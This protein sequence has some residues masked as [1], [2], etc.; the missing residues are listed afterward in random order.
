MK[1]FR[2]LVE[3]LIVYQERHGVKFRWGGQFIA[4]TE[5]Q[6]PLS[7]YLRASEA[8]L[9]NVGIG[10]EHASERIRKLMRKGFD[11]DALDDTINNLSKSKIYTMMNFMS[12]HPLETEDDHNENLKFMKNYQWASDNG[13]I[14]SLNLQHYIAFLPGTD[15]FD[16]KDELVEYDVGP[17]WKNDNL[18][19]P[20]IHRRRK[21]V[22]EQCAKFGWNT[23]NEISFMDYM[24]RELEYY[25][26][27]KSNPD[28]NRIEIHEV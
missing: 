14:A 4:R 11:N 13:T 1:T 5:E 3:I 24:D 20:L 7:D 22:S 17:F 2:E 6:M 26:N 23:Y 18:D 21:E 16:K 12:G 27:L 25:N 8:G 9:E 28:I 15:F 19:F 10:L